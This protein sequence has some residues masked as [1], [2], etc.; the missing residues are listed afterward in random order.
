MRRVLPVE[1]RAEE[2]GA[3]RGLRRGLRLGVLALWAGSALA[4]ATTPAPAPPGLIEATEQIYVVGPPDVLQIRILPDPVIERT[5]VVRPDGRITVDLIGD[6]RADGLTLEEIAREIEKRIVRFKRGA[7]ATVSLES[8]QSTSITVLG[9]VNRPG[10]FPLTSET[11]VSQLMG[12]VG[13]PTNFA[14]NSRVRV[15]RPGEETP[16]VYRIDFAAIRR[17]DLRTNI[18]TGNTQ[19]VLDGGLDMFIEASLKSGL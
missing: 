15:I 10:S 4:C 14:W 11:R 9:E 6:L 8:A 13:G 19:A 17:G 12:Q 2:G 18:E 3:R 16:V 1:S 5:A 7:Y